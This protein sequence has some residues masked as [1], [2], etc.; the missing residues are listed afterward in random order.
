MKWTRLAFLGTLT[1]LALSAALWATAD[2]PA[3][4]VPAPPDA[5]VVPEAQA[6]L[7]LAGGIGEA[8]YTGT[9]D[10]NCFWRCP[11]GVVINTWD[12]WATVTSAMACKNQC[13]AACL[14][15]CGLL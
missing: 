14:T 10:P 2:A 4:I 8:E 5:L 7:D 1:V 6:P 12:G 3:P 9:G 13:K 15:V 11:G